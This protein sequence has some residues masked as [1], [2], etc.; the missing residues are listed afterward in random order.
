M[1][2]TGEMDKRRH[3]GSTLP[4]KNKICTNPRKFP[5]QESKE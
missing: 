3:M 1:K 5:T 4:A 2:G